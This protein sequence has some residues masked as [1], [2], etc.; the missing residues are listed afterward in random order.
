MAWA[1]AWAEAGERCAVA[2]DAR[3]HAAERRLALQA[4]YIDKGDVEQARAGVAATIV[5]LR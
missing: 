5:A 2:G 4:M 1:L 3:A